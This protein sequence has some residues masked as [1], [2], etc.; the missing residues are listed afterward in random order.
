MCI[1][2]RHW[3]AY[4]PVLDT[5][6]HIAR[7]SPRPVLIIGAKEDERTPAGQSELLFEAAGEPRRLRFTAGQ[8]IQPNRKEII[9]DLLRIADEELVF[10]S[11][12]A[13]DA[14]DADR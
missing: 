4:G 7:V 5:R 8:H 6:E 11:D 1:R 13:T 3:L 10:L 14:S 2:D 9:A 12:R